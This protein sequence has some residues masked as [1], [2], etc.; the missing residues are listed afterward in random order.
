MDRLLSL[1]HSVERVGRNINSL[2][3]AKERTV[4][5]LSAINISTNA[6]EVD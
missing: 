1:D 2:V 6:T 5:M 3:P 4:Q